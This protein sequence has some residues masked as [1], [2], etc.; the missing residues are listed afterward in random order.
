MSDTH[1]SEKPLPIRQTDD[2][3]WEVENSP[4][5]WTKCETKADATAISNAPLLR[6]RS[7]HT[8]YPNEGIA[9]ELEETAAVLEKYRIRFDSRFFRRQAKVVRC[10]DPDSSAL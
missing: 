4:G 2:G 10:E 9:A 8:D 5:H 7:F 3:Q 1:S 6:E